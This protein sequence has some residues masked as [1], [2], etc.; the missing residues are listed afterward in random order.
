MVQY[1]SIL[2]HSGIWEDHPAVIT[3]RER[4]EQFRNGEQPPEPHW[5]Y[6]IRLTHEATQCLARILAV[7]SIIAQQPRDAWPSDEEWR[8]MLPAWFVKSFATY[9]VEEAQAL[10]A[11]LPKEQWSEI[12]WEFGSWLDAIRGRGWEWWS[13]KQAEAELQIHLTLNEWPASLEAFEVIVKA[14]GGQQPTKCQRVSPS[15][16]CSSIIGRL[17]PKRQCPIATRASGAAERTL[18]TE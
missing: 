4:I 13:F 6:T 2:Y 7:V 14:S 16:G 1:N 18:P 12:P 5:T 17:R 8:Q 3:E 11:R 9:T 15:R 10:L